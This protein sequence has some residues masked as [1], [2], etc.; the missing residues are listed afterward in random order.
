MTTT[1]LK[2]SLDALVGTKQVNPTGVTY[3][4]E[5]YKIVNNTNVVIFMPNPRNYTINE[6][7]DFVSNLSPAPVPAP[8]PV[9]VPV[10]EAAVPSTMN[11]QPKTLQVHPAVQYLPVENQII[12]ETLLD[13]IARIKKDK[14]Y[15]PQANAIC[16]TINNY[17][18]LQKNEIQMIN[19]LNKY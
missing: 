5:K 1:E 16:N 8:A 11:Q 3:T 14:E 6:A 12:K 7:I 19:T 2:N 13:T 18:A 4:I 17:I 10:P 9:P 15:I